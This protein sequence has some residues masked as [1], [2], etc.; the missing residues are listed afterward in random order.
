MACFYQWFSLLQENG[1]RIMGMEQSIAIIK[2]LNR[3]KLF[4]I[5][6]GVINQRQTMFFQARTSGSKSLFDGGTRRRTQYVHSFNKNK[7]ERFVAHE[8]HFT[9]TCAW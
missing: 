1:T 6:Y 5:N 9:F 3:S 2:D 8:T 4:R 7:Q